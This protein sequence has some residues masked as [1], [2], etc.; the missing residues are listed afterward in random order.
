M[1]KV[2]EAS[3]NGIRA[4]ISVFL[5]ALKNANAYPSVAQKIKVKKIMGRAEHK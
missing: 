5:T 4:V 3:I 1:R 2:S